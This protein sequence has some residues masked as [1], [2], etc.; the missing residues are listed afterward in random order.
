MNL[1][2]HIVRKDTRRLALPLALWI[3]LIVVPLAA[4]RFA[5]PSF[6]GHVGVAIDEIARMAS[7]WVRLLTGIQLVFG[8]ILAAALVLEDRLVDASAFWATRPIARGRLLAAKLVAAVLLFVVLPIVALLPVWLASGFGARDLALAA[9]HFMCMHGAATLVALTF[10]SIS[11][12]LAQ[13]LFWTIAL[14]VAEIAAVVLSASYFRGV[15][16][17]VRVA[18]DTLAHVSLVPM[19]GFV[20]VQQFLTLRVPRAWVTL[21]LAF[22]ASLAIRATWP[23][24]LGS[25]I[26]VARPAAAELPEDRA[27]AIVPDP[28]LIKF[29]ENALPTLFITA[30]WSRERFYLPA[31][32][33]LPSG[34]VTHGA[35]G[36]GVGEVGLRLLGFSQREEPLRW[37]VMASGLNDAQFE[38]TLM[39]WVASARVIGEAPLHVGEEFKGGGTRSKIISLV[40]NEGSRLDQIYLQETEALANTEAAWLGHPGARDADRLRYLDRYFLVQRGTGKAQAVSSSEVARVEMHSL[41]IRFRRLGV[42]GDGAWND[43]V[44]IKVRYERERRLERPLD[45]HGVKTVTRK[46]PP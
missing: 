38:G 34:A 13:V 41:V 24:S 33:R 46:S 15:P 43:A 10:A 29:S 25:G 45:V 7:I 5:T 3:V 18:R 11:R 9:W 12:N 39:V 35:T 30:P 6:E 22:V 28:T 20:L 1:V 42:H 23:S 2:W 31:F 21:A 32:V 4:F 26:E 37:Q 19:F 36:P 14:V 40:R 17:A 16:I 44:L 8:Y 27:V